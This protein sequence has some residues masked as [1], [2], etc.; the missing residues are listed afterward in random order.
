[1]ALRVGIVGSGEMGRKYAAALARNVSDVAFVGVSG[2]TRAAALANEFGIPE[3]DVDAVISSGMTDAVIIA[4]PHST[5]VPLAVAAARAGKHIYIEKP[6]ARNIAECD[7]ILDACEATGVT[8]A[9]NTVTRFRPSPMAAKQALDGGRIGSLR[10]L[11]V[12]SSAVGYDPDYKS[13]TSDPAEGGMW[14]DWGCHGCDVI[15]WFVGMS[16]TEAF[17]RMADYSGGPA[18]DRS[19][20]AEFAFANGVTAQLLMSVELPAPGLGSAS[21]WTLI[22]SDG[23]IE[24]DGYAKARLG[25]AD[26]WQELSDQQAF[27]FINEPLA[28]HLIAGFAAQVQDFVDAVRGGRS[29]L[30][31]GQDGRASVEMV[32]AARRSNRLGRS[33]GLP[34]AAEAS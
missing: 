15:R 3:L 17:G 21:Q 7:A 12:L 29:P 19:V 25:T 32:E 33:V 27:D 23:I 5:H 28:P 34:L 16:P 2:G 8:I 14:L 26:G 4:T 24:L 6:L 11:R 22:G 20:M 10:M 13:W 1:M 30:V 9:V 31:T 18:L